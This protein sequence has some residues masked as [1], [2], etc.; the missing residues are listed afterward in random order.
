MGN[1]SKLRQEA[2]R[3]G[4]LLT[5]AAA[6]PP[7]IDPLLK[8]NGR[9][10]AVAVGSVKRVHNIT[11]GEA[12]G[13]TKPPEAV[14]IR[15]VVGTFVSYSMTLEDKGDPTAYDDLILSLT[16]PVDSIRVELPYGQ[17]SLTFDAYVSKVEDELLSNLGGVRRW[18]NCTVT[19]TPMRAQIKP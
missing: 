13:R 7:G 1:V 4:R 2:E 5:A 8:I 9:Y 11:D 3:S 12:A 18:G 15:D 10:Y 17:H 14:M 19:F 16:R 6:V